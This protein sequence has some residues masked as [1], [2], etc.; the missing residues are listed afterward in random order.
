LEKCSQKIDNV[1]AAGRALKLNSIV[2]IRIFQY[3][4][5]ALDN[6]PILQMLLTN[7]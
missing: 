4:N 2:F 6:I 1:I 7:A 5:L 3:L